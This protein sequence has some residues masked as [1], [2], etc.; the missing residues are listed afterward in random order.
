MLKKYPLPTSRIY[1]FAVAALCLALSALSIG[2]SSKTNDFASLKAKGLEHIGAGEYEKAEELLSLALKKQPSDRET[3]FF[4]GVSQSNLGMDS[5]AVS[6][7]RKVIKLHGSDV[8]TAR[9]L[10]LASLAAEDWDSGLDGLYALVDAGEPFNT[11]FL[12]FYDM[13]Y[14]SGRLLNASR[15]MDSLIRKDPERADYYL[16]AANLKGQIEMYDEAEMQL[17]EALRRFGPSV[18]IYS[19]LGVL[20]MQQENF[21]RAEVMFRKGVTLA[22]TNDGA[23][24]NLANCLSISSKPEARQEAVATYRRM[25]QITFDRLRLDTVVSRLEYE[26]GN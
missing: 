17:Q 10:I 26:L 24:M 16:K 19:N 20:Q 9:N 6:S 2:C 14:R 5:L 1:F 12:E 21:S 8:E 23:L 25:S 3:M 22:P 18:E 15:M 4:L 7:F 11:L 13:Y